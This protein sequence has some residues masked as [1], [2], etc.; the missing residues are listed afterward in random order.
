MSAFAAYPAP[1]LAGEVRAGLASETTGLMRPSLEDFAT[2]DP[3]PAAEGDERP[4][5]A[6]RP[7]PF[8]TLRPGLPREAA[9]SVGLAAAPCAPAPP[10]DSTA[11]LLAER[12]AAL[13]A[14]LAEGL[15]DSAFL[16]AEL[17][18]ALR[19]RLC[20]LLPAL[21]DALAPSLRDA[22][23]LPRL[24]E[25]L[26]RLA[27]AGSEIV[28]L[29]VAPE[30]EALAARA[31]SRCS[32]APPLRTSPALGPGEMRLRLAGDAARSLDLDAALADLVALV[33]AGLSPPLSPVVPNADQPDH[34]PANAGSG[35]TSS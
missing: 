31:L 17:E 9:P 10:Q 3:P 20:A 34:R 4:S 13:A 33:E 1:P 11:D 12:E 22:A 15:A 32:A 8:A 28:A 19:A 5:L 26:A 30:A 14:R 6:G 35:Q 29:E 21:L 18:A 7:A 16:R 24:A 25:E 2:P 27:A 23:F